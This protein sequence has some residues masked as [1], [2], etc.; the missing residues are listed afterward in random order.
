MPTLTTAE[1]TA[2]V[3]DAFKKMVPAINFFATDLSSDTAK[4]GQQIIAHVAATPSATDHDQNVGFFNSPSSAKDLLTD[5]PVTIDAWKDVNLK[6]AANDLVTDR[7]PKYVETVQNAAW[8]LG[9]AMIDSVLAKVLAANISYNSVCTNAN[10]TYGKLR[11]FSA[12]LNSQGAGIP[13]FGL[14]SSGFMS[15]LLAD[16]MIASGDYFNQ[17]QEAS[18]LA[19]LQNIAGFNSVMEY[20]DFPANGQNLTGFFFDRRAVVVASR[21]PND[22]IALAQQR[23]VPVPLRV[24]TQTDAETGLSVLAIERLNTSTLDIELTY[25]VMFGSAVG[26]QGGSAGTIMDKAG[27]RVV[28][29]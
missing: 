1:I 27:H 20:S 23:G 17:R 25:S 21:L 12:A 2:D 14:V 18:A 5:V 29:A 7:V 4:F 22:S 11:A 13:R 28:T 26:K 9:K 6:F 19:L 8:A 16:T 10:A 15:G 24:E 3:F